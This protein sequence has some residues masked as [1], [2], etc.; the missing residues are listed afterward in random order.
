MLDGHQ[1]PPPGNLGEL[2]TVLVT[3]AAF[4][5]IALASRRTR[6]RREKEAENYRSTLNRIATGEAE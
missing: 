1:P 4:L 2:A 6:R 5:A 3:P